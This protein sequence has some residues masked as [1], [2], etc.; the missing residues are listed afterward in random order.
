MYTD[1]GNPWALCTTW[2]PVCF[3]SLSQQQ[4]C[5]YS[6]HP[7]FHQRVRLAGKKYNGSS[8]NWPHLLIH[9]RPWTL[10]FSPC[11]ECRKD[12]WGEIQQLW[13]EPSDLHKISKVPDW[14]MMKCLVFFPLSLTLS[15]RTT[16]RRLSREGCADDELGEICTIDHSDRV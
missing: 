15:Q 8:P 3:P 10:F 7:G 11:P 16:Q 5:F 13:K 2:F 1:M 4:N 14:H 12:A 9:N 6:R